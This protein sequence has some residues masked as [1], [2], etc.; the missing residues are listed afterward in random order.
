VSSPR[1]GITR[2]EVLVLLVIFVI[3]LGLVV[4]YLVRVRE[5]AG[6]AHCANNLRLIGAGAYHFRGKVPRDLLEK[7]ASGLP[8]PA[9]RIADGY[10]TWAVQ[11]APY[12]TDKS[13]LGDWDLRKPYA[14]QDPAARQAA[15]TVYFCPTRPRTGVLS[16]SG[17]V[18]PGALGDY[19]CASADGDPAFPWDSAKANGAI[20][21]AE[22]LEKKDE[23]IL[24]WRAR[25][26]FASLKR[27]V[28]NTILIGEKHVPLGTFG[29]AA[30]GDGSLYNGAN[31]ASFAR[32]GGPGFGLAASPTAP[33]N[34]NF[35]SY[36]PAVCQFLMADGSV[37]PMSNA[38]DENILG[39]L[40]RR[41]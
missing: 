40:I 7:K 23:M 32:V 8:L 9:S 28:S 35:G 6:L 5:G 15:L 26:G 19:A 16:T 12:V 37:R 11:L 31:L 27:G 1:K 2:I 4:S 21:P 20:I 17:D 38:V 14:D 10:A 18:A 24:R 22:V 34:R 36:H 33:F 30:S 25:T 41:E 29:E 39:Q 3:L 13:P